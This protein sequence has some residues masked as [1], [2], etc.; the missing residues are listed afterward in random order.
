MPKGIYDRAPSAWKPK[1]KKDYDP[2]LVEK[3]RELYAAGHTMREIAELA[4][5]TVKILQR[6]MPRHGIT[7]R[8]AAKRDQAG[9][10][11]HMWRGG[12]AKYQAL[13]LRVETARGKPQRCSCCDTDDPNGKYEWANLSGHYA[14]IHDYARLCIP[15]HRRLD[16]RR[17]AVT[18]QRTMPPKGGEGDV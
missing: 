12:E 11:N 2:A 17:R 6:L 10:R 3:V 18:G 5:T 8:T 13:H 4:G 7:R 15:C 9:E 14:D 1:P 16:A